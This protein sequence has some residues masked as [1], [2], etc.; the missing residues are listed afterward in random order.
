M[1]AWP[2]DL[3][4]DGFLG[5]DHGDDDSRLVSNMDSGPALVRKRFTAYT[6]SIAVPMVLT[7]AQYASFL[8]F[9]R[10]TLNQG[11]G[12]FTWKNPVD[13]SSVSMR[14]TAPPRFKSIKSG[15]VADRL[16]QGTLSLE[17]LP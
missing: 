8:T 3:P 9:Y 17:I 12:P 14:F 4:Q 10:T 13:D 6:Q 2:A 7:G 15:A 1:S 16:W 5:T 11:T